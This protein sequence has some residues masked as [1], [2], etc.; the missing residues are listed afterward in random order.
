[1]TDTQKPGTQ[2]PGTQQPGT[3]QDSAPFVRQIT[4]LVDHAGGKD[5]LVRA[6]GK[7]VSARTLDN[8]VRGDYPRAAVT[9]AVREL[10]R[11]ALA[12]GFGYPEAA[13]APRL[14]DACGPAAG[15]QPV[16]EP[17]V[18]ETG[19]TRRR[20]LLAASAAALVLATAVVSVLVTLAVVGRTPGPAATVTVAAPTTG[21]PPLPTTGDGTLYTEQTGSQGSNTFADPRTLA[22]GNVPVPAATDVQ[23]VCRYYAPSIPSVAPDGFWYLL[24]T[25]GW[26]GRWAPANTFWNGDVPGVYPYTHNTDFAVPLCS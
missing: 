20:A 23:V 18:A 4:W 24:D 9:G 26:A 25:E 8:W 22:D 1:M 10:D 7:K 15:A 5:A 3:A 14:I 11:W 19:P 17:R 2:Q 13:G 6:T 12:Q 21:L 16:D